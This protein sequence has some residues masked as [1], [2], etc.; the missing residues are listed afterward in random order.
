MVL[1]FIT[2]RIRGVGGRTFSCSCI[3]FLW[4]V[5]LDSGCIVEMVVLWYPAGIL[6]MF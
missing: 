6:G 4:G 5:E 2:V 3:N 1:G